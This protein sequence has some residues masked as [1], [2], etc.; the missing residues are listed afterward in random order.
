MP[1]TFKVG[2]VIQIVRKKL[3]MGRDQALFLMANG[4][5]LMKQNSDL[6]EMFDKFVDEDG[7]L[8]ITY[9]TENTLGY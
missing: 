4:K 6:T 9:A 2:E 3:S 5:H 7:F 8:Y 1:K